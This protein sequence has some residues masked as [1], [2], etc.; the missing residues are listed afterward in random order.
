MTTN[1]QPLTRRELAAAIPVHMQTITKWEHAGMPV[2]EPGRKGKPSLYS[3][4]DVKKWRADQEA[5]AQ[6]NGTARVAVERARKERAQA[7]LAEQ[8]YETRAG[9]LLP[10]DEVDRVWASEVAG[11]R[12]VLLSLATTYAARIY[13]AATLNGEA[14]VARALADAAREVLRELA[15]PQGVIRP[16][17]RSTRS[18]RKK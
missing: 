7:K 8:M 6:T 18:S 2:L 10:R 14:G 4:A 16:T 1:G 15:D 5:A 11:V 9:E 13:R 3:L 12:A 17:P